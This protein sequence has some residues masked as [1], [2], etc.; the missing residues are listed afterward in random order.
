M[1]DHA[2][3]IREAV[4]EIGIRRLHS[5][6]ADVIT[7]RAWPE[8]AH[9]MTAECTL[10][11]DLGDRR[12]RH[13]GPSAIGSFIAAAVE[14]FSFFELVVLNTVTE[15]DSSAGTAGARM[16][17]VEVRELGDE[18]HRS[19]AFGLYHDRLVRGTDRQWRFEHRRYQSMARGAPA[20]SQRDL[21]VFDVSYRALDQL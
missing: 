12:S 6:Y 20:G 5:R 11:L 16:Y 7:R 8:L 13:D 18:G 1:E 14:R 4:D 17:T 10:D 9:I 2:D 21:E 19:D 15:I 3:D